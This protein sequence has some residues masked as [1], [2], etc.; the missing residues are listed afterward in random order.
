MQVLFVGDVVGRTGR[1]CLRELLPAL[2]EKHRADLVVANGENAAGGLGLT[3]KAF[4]EL[5]EA[6]VQVITGGNHIWDKKEVFQ[7][8]DTEPSVLRPANYPR[9]TTPGR[10][11]AVFHVQD[12]PVGVLHLVGRIFMPPVDCPFQR[13]DEEI[14]LLRKEAAVILVDF[15]AEATSE[16]QAMGW[17]LDGRVSAVIGTHTH[18][19]TADERILPGGTAYIT[20]AGM[21]GLY[22]SI[23]GVDR[24]GALD[25]FLTR[26]PGRLKV[27]PGPAMLNA[28]LVSVD[29]QTGTARGIRRIRELPQS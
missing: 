9:D 10:G 23:L 7:F 18:V 3:A 4:T 26:L 27:S 28:V 6:G 1:L 25:K 29:P 16:K 12:I 19:Q 13:A 11:S 8:I 5:K 22:D 20:D 21:T 15:H 24:E 14:A 2:A 17:H